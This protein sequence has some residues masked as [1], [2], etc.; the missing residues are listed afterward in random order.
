MSDTRSPK[1]YGTAVALCGVFGVL[2]VHHFY[3]GNILHG[4]VDLGLFLV[5]VALFCNGNPLALVFLL[6]DAL[7]TVIVFY[8]LITEQERDGQGRRICLA[9]TPI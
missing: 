4:L 1:S 3:L 9:S 6:A 2:G 5:T 8:K 7:H